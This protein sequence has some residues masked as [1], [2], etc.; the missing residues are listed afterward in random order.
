[1]NLLLHFKYRSIVDN[2]FMFLGKIA[3][4]IG[5]VFGVSVGMQEMIEESGTE[6]IEIRNQRKEEDELSEQDS[7][8]LANATGWTDLERKRTSRNQIEMILIDY[9]EKKAANLKPVQL[10]F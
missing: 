2:V 3:L 6:N 10:S 1:M 4:V 5:I 8:D 7:I 9:R